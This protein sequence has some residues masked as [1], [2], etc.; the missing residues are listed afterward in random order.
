MK[1]KIRNVL[2]FLEWFFRDSSQETTT[3][4][5]RLLTLKNIFYTLFI[6]VVVA[7]L[8]GRDMWIIIFLLANII[9]LILLGKYKSGKW[10]HWERE[11]LYK[12]IGIEMPK[13]RK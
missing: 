8:W 2:K 12:K 4:L 13:R 6:I 3:T 5:K 1:E 10:R 9:Y 7:L 11:S